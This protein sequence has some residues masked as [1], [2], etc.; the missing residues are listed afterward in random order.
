MDK[1]QNIPVVFKITEENEKNSS[2]V[3]DKTD[4]LLLFFLYN[5][6]INN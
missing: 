2:F 1:N 3:V 6:K 4:L 5:S